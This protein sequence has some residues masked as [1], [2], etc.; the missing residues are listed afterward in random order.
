MTRFRHPR[1]QKPIVMCHFFT[2]KGRIIPD[3]IYSQR[4]HP[5]V[6][7]ARRATTIADLARVISG[8]D[9]S[10]GLRRTLLA[11]AERLERLAARRIDELGIPVD[12]KKK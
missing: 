10:S 8:R 7:I 3:S 12:F 2:H 6:R 4:R 11:Q 9:V 5:D 1:K